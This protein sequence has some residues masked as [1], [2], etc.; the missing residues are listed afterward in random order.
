[1]MPMSPDFRVMPIR[2]DKIR[3]A[4]KGEE[5]TLQIYGVCRGGTGTTVLAHLHDEVFGMA[6]KADDLSAVFACHG[7]H[8]EIDGRTRKT[9]GED[10]TWY[11]LRG[12]QRTI[13]RLVERGI[14]FVPITV[15]K[16]PSQ[17]PVKPRKP[18][19]ERVPISSGRKLVSRNTLR[20]EPR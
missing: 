10:L 19:V 20:K 2:S 3:A 11:K 1:M 9:Q 17:R 6:R 8:D 12:L 15:E 16:P 14:I 5:C 13:R 4:A 7:C 18:K